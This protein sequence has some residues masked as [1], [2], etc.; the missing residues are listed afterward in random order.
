[1]ES[2]HADRGKLLLVDRGG[3][4]TTSVSVAKDG[5]SPVESYS[6]TV[7]RHVLDTGRGVWVADVTNDARFRSGLSLAALDLKTVICVPVRWHGH[8]RALLY[9]DRREASSAFTREDFRQ[10]E[11]LTGYGA[12]ALAHAEMADR[13]LE[14]RAREAEARLRLEV[15]EERARDREALL[16]QLVH[17]LRGPLQAIA[18]MN[19]DL[20]HDA[21]ERPNLA[22]TV[23]VIERQVSFM[24]EFL[25]QKFE[26][27]SGSRGDE[28]AELGEVLDE[29]DVRYGPIAE[30]KALHLTIDKVDGVVVPMAPVE[31]AQ[32]LGNLVDNAVKFTPT[33]GLVEVTARAA[34]GWVVVDVLDSG[35]GW[36]R[37]NPSQFGYGLGLENVRRLVQ[38]A[39]GW[40]SIEAREIG[41]T[42]ARLGLPTS[43]WGQM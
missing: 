19:M 34:D 1:M 38:D 14:L 3:T 32:A 18:L 37:A 6:T 22:G 27:L 26:R 28:R 35:V 17:D 40:M 31:L 25:Q 29:L 7:V 5:G 39:G 12:L 11:I 15:A 9:L 2:A 36:G 24:A 4:M 41:G 30:A 13:D 43:D 21:V 42:V 8:L 23:S 33:R 20:A 10:V 16:R